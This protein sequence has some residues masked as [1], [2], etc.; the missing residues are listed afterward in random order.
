MQGKG[1][2]DRILEAETENRR[3]ADDLEYAQ[4]QALLALEAANPDAFEAAELALREAAAALPETSGGGSGGASDAAAAAVD[5]DGGDGRSKAQKKKEKEREKER[6]KAKERE[7]RIAA[8]RASAGPSPRDVELAQ[9]ARQLSGD[10]GAGGGAGGSLAGPALPPL[11]VHEVLSDGHCLYRAVDHQLVQ[12]GLRPAALEMVRDG[13]GA[14]L[15]RAKAW[16][17]LLSRPLCRRVGDGP[18]RRLVC[19]ASFMV[20][21]CAGWLPGVA[22]TGLGVHAGAPRRLRTLPGLA[23]AARRSRLRVGLWALL[24]QGIVIPGKGPKKGPLVVVG[25]ERPRD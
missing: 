12:R 24:R 19:Y 1:Q 13:H 15:S 23:A 2:A 8:E 18:P 4:R 9:L 7:A 3:A 17:R 16:T 21:L 22:G 5:A 6:A 25:K 14:I 10:A 20:V 11:R